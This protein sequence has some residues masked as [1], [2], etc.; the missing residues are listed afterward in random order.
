[1]EWQDDAIVLSARR[2]GETDTILSA[3]TFEHG[4][5]LGL[6]K[7][8]VGRRMRPLLQPGNR[9]TCSWRARLS[10]HLGHFTIEPA[11]LYA[12]TLLEDPLRL[13]A[14]GSACSVLE[15]ALAERDP[16][17]TLYAA[18]LTLLGRLATEVGWPDAYVRFELLLLGDL[19]FGL[20]LT[21]CAVTGASDNLIYVSPRSGRAVSA[22]GAGQYA[23]KLLPLPA[24]LLSKGAPVD[25][26]AVAQGLQ[27]TG[28]FLRRHIL[29]PADRVM[30]AARERLVELWNRR[31]ENDR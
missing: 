18:L 28:Y 27:L 10:D 22:A 8:G 16:H 15:T 4:R 20:D 14:V 19:G 9:V 26:K 13:A 24:F 29:E 17:G 30:P 6:V 1:M 2:H 5:H 23:S 7:G 25:G 11:R 21:C 31:M 12:T 3:M